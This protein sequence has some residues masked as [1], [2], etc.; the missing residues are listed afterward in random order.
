[1]H[2]VVSR[3]APR[4]DQPDEHEEADDECDDDLEHDDDR[5]HDEHDDD[6]RE[7][8]INRRLAVQSGGVQASE[9]SVI[10]S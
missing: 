7:P 4:S 1:M 10:W 3:A 8:D 9:C 2:D 6:E 5:E